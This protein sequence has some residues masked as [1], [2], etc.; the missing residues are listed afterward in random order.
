[1]VWYIITDYIRCCMDE[2][3]KIKEKVW[4]K[5]AASMQKTTF[6]NGE[7]II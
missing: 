7:M 3:E 5:P 6:T 2:V 4:D 1:M